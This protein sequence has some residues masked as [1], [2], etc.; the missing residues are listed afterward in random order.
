MIPTELESCGDRALAAVASAFANQ[1]APELSD[2]GQQRREQ[3][4]LRARRV[5]EEIVR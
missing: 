2:R 3:S 4:A 1:L 5:P